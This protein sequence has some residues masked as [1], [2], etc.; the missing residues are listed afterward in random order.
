MPRSPVTLASTT[1]LMDVDGGRITWGLSGDPRV[2]R[3]R[4]R[5]VALASSPR[6][7][8]RFETASTAAGLGWFVLVFLYVAWWSMERRS[9]GRTRRRGRP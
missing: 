3:V 4:A 8:E 2:G 5:R 9:G 1:E 6:R 7:M